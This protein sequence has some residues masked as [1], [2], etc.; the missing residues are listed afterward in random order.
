MRFGDLDAAIRL[1]AGDSDGRQWDWQDYIRRELDRRDR[2]VLRAT[3][4]V[5]IEEERARQAL[6]RRC[7]AL[8][9]ELAE[10]RELLKQD[11]S[12]GLRSVPASG[13]AAMIA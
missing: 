3:A 1:I 8:E 7:A 11:R 12:R 5:V 9:A 10:L 6:E 13:P 4:Q 2:A